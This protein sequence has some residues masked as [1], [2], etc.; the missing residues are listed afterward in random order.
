MTGDTQASTCSWMA[1]GGDLH[2]MTGLSWSFC[3]HVVLLSRG[4]WPPAHSAVN[5]GP[6]LSVHTQNCC[7]ALF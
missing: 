1:L 3:S 4:L 6:V 5:G 2:H 7:F